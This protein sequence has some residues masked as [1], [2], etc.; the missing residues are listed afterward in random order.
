MTGILI[1]DIALFLYAIVLP[2]IALA[3][4]WLQSDEWLLTVTL[5]TAIGVF[6]LPLLAFSL[7]VLVRTHISATFILIQGTVVLAIAGGILWKRRRTK[8]DA[9]TGS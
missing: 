2:G 6:T 1:A 8:L 4:V 3:C 5:G 7:A 9:T